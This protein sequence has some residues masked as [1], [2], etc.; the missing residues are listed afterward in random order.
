TPNDGGQGGGTQE[1][2]STNDVPAGET[3]VYAAFTVTDAASGD[4]VLTAMH[5]RGVPVT[6]LFAPECLHDC[7]DLVRRAAA[8]GC[9]VGLYI[10]EESGAAA[11][12]S[13]RAAN[14]LLWAHANRKTRIIYA[15]AG[16]GSVEDAL[17]QAGYRCFTP[18]LD[19]SARTLSGEQ[20]IGALASA[21]RAR[22][23]RCTLYLGEDTHFAASAAQ[24]VTLMRAKSCTFA[25]LT[26]II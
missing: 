25:K 8:L 10:S 13:A 9:T 4:R 18:H 2:G 22:G 17:T 16:T 24:I 23:T 6:L 7:G 26:E 20:S 19:Y 1:G 21:V 12:E 14:A 3:A 11:V 15:A 5:S